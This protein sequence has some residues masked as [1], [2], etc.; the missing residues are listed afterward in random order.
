VIIS[1][2]S[3]SWG[4]IIVIRL[5]REFSLIGNGGTKRGVGKGVG[6]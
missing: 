3:G 6:G 4:D 1:I 2:N 5:D